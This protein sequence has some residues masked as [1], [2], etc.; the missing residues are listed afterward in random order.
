MI[1]YPPEKLATPLTRVENLLFKIVQKRVVK[2]AQFCADF[3]TAQNSG[4]KRKGK[5]FF[6]GKLILGTKNS[7]HFLTQELCTFLKPARNRAIRGGATF[8]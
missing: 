4:V 2:E 5:F 6:P 3:K 8:S 7:G 1:F